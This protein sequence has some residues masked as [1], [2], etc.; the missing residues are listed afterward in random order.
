MS[1]ARALASLRTSVGDGEYELWQV[2]NAK[3][4]FTDTVDG[5]LAM[6]RAIERLVALDG[7]RRCVVN[8]HLIDETTTG[9]GAGRLAA[10]AAVS[11][12]ATAA[13]SRSSP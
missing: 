3:R 11:A 6:R 8:S 2:I 12:R 9:H 4:P 10:G 13:D 1:G 5:C 7:H